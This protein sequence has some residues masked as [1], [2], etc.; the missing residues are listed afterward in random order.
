MDLS[1]LGWIATISGILLFLSL[2]LGQSRNK[3]VFNLAN[4]FTLIGAL[5]LLITFV[6]Y[7][8]R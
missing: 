7:M 2:F 6:V 4:A 1:P 3:A 8:F 5:G